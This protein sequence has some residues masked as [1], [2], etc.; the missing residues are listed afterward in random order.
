MKKSI[1]AMLSMFITLLLGN[2]TYAQHINSL[3][4]RQIKDFTR[5]LANQHSVALAQVY[6][7]LSSIITP[8]EQIDQKIDMRTS[9]FVKGTLGSTVYDNINFAGTK[10]PIG[11]AIAD[12]LRSLRYQFSNN[13]YTALGEV[14][15]VAS[16]P[17]SVSSFSQSVE[18]FLDSKFPMLQNNTERLILA[19][20][21][22]IA[23]DSYNYWNNNIDQWSLVIAQ[24][25]G[26]SAGFNILKADP[27]SIAKADLG[28]AVTG[29]ARGVYAG[30]VA[31]SMAIPGIGTVTGAAA[32]GLTGMIGGAIL[33]SA[34][35]GV[36]YL[37]AR[38]FD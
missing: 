14:E 13:L 38:L 22:Y 21:A 16:S 17:I 35:S 29:L 28:G 11:V 1:F 33:S 37:I 23:L 36:K 4:N 27:S 8:R 34:S 26:A 20:A 31:G 19:G 6:S 3:T 18:S 12:H 10:M 30:V 5:N 2:I 9:T 32:C 15:Q 25:G 7:N 24:S